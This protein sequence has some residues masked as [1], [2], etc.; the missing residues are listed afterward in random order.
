MSLVFAEVQL[1][2]PAIRVLGQGLEIEPGTEGSAFAMENRDARFGI[3]RK[4]NKRVIQRSRRFRI[5][6]IATIRPA[7]RH[8]RN[9]A[10]LVDFYVQRC[11]RDSRVVHTHHARSSF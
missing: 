8:G 6:G 7:E 2:Y 9:G 4:R 1:L 11:L 10:G 3:S 5:D